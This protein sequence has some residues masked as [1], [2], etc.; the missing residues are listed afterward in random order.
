MV[1]MNIADELR[2][3]QALHHSGALTDDEF[4]AA[5]AAVLAGQARGEESAGEQAMQRQLDE[6]K[7][8][9]ELARLDRE[10]A[11]MVPVATCKNRRRDQRGYPWKTP[12]GAN[13]VRIMMHSFH[14][15]SA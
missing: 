15:R 11:P 5:K 8:E 10:W 1:L 3:L 6:L 4:A 12:H 2:K 9:N 7:L 13:R 14:N